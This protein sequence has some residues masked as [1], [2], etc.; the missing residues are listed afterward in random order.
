MEKLEF[1]FEFKDIGPS[2]EFEGW[3]STYDLDLG[4]DKV[5]P[6]AF[7]TS[8]RKTG[9]R[10]PVLFNHE[11]SKIVGVG[12]EAL[13][14]QRGL[15]VKAKLAMNTQL[16]R[17]THELM[18]MGALRGLSIG[19]SVEPKGWVM[20]G[21]VRLLK[22]VALHEYSATP[23][24]MNTEAQISRVKAV[25]EMS[26]R[27]LE[28]QLRDVF[29]LSQKEAKKVIAEGFRVLK[30]QRDVS[31]DDDIATEADAFEKKIRAQLESAAADTW[32]SSL[33]RSL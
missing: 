33:S 20:D 5:L 1:A 22:A 4:N 29:G 31:S 28:E 2:G 12:T 16:G 19:Y 26:D 30:G 24:P 17:E 23:F 18:S 21:T 10:V 32:L 7:K 27:E 15:Y 25:A 8:L 6:G 11:R 13:E 14:D 9:G 3:A